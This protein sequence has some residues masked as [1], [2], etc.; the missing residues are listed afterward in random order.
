MQFG[1]DKFF[2]ISQE[3]L[4]IHSRRAEVLAGN[5]ANADTPGYKARDIDFKAALQ[6][7]KNGTGD[8]TLRTT[9]PNHINS[10][11]TSPGRIDDVLGEMKYRIP[12]QPS[13]DGNTVDSLKEKAAFMENALLYQTNLQFL[14]G[15]IK[16][17][18]AAL[19]GE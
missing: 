5:L 18:K 12:S 6:Q 1:L 11:G 3:A 13:L 2:G 9:N 14:G 17:L 15:K 8:V 19:K 7:I 4:K 16:H 10:A